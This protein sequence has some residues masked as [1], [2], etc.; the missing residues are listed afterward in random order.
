[1]QLINSIAAEFK[2]E[3][4]QLYGDQLA[5]LVLF[6]SY[7]R[8]DQNEESDVDFAVVLKNP[9]TR[10]TDEVIRLVPVS[11]ALSLKYR[12]IV[13]VLPVSEQKLNTSMQGVYQEIR[14]EGIRL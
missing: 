2:R 3:L 5:G 13:S 7:A 1:M 14:R 12:C 6:G 10:S 4:R 9:E 11:T 8:G